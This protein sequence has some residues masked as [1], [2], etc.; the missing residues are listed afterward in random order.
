MNITLLFPSPIPSRPFS[1]WCFLASGWVTPDG[2]F[3]PDI[4]ESKVF[5]SLDTES[6]DF[7]CDSVENFLFPLPTSDLLVRSAVLRDLSLDLTVY[8]SFREV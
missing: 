1:V 4:K 6:L 5:Y 7:I 3:S 8:L 2:S